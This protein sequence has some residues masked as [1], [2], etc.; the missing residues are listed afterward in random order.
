M[1]RDLLGQYHVSDAGVFYRGDD[2]VLA[3]DRDRCDPTTDT[4]TSPERHR[5]PAAVLPDDEDARSVEANVLAHQTLLPVN[6]ATW[7]RS[8]PSTA[9]P[10]PTTAR[11][12]CCKSRRSALVNGPGQVQNQFD[13]D[14]TVQ[15]QLALL[16]D[17][18]GDADGRLRQPAHVAGGRWPALRRAR[19]CRGVGG[20]ALSAAAEGVGLVRQH[21]GFENTYAGAINAL[22]RTP[23]TPASSGTNR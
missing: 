3:T 16:R 1:Q 23:A 6:A 14:P 4:S 2:G 22:R 19:L 10:G 20:E 18:G 5:R 9:I 7:R 17:R 12:G 8:W 11:S 15:Q 21:I 13:S